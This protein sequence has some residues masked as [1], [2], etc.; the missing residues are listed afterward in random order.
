M[1]IVKNAK[2][3]F[4]VDDEPMVLTGD[5]AK[6]FREEMER[7]RTPEEIARHTAFLA[8][9]RASVQRAKYPIDE[10]EAALRKQVAE[11]EIAL[12][13]EC[14]HATIPRAELIADPLKWRGYCNMTV[15]DEEGKPG[16]YYSRGCKPIVDDDWWADVRHLLGVI[17]RFRAD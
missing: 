16:G 2:G 3:E 5:A 14:T 7:E 17:D 15:V 10:K 12:A 1:R 9:C 6:V 4:E 8:E 11:L 13:H